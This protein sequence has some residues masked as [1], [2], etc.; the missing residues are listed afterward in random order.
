MVVMKG[1][2]M[3]A[4]SSPIRFAPMGRIAPIS[5]ATTTAKNIVILIIPAIIRLF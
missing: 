2:A 5:F 4:G 1:D 3:T